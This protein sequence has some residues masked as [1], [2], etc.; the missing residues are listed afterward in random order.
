MEDV[1]KAL[2]V[3]RGGEGRLWRSTARYNVAETAWSPQRLA[4]LGGGVAHEF[5]CRCHGHTKSQ[6]TTNSSLNLGIMYFFT[7]YLKL[8]M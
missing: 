8:L 4:L 7:P 5:A 3:A 2:R 1:F 6:H